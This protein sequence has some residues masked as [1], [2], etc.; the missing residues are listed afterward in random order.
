MGFFEKKEE[1]VKS[2]TCDD[3]IEWARPH[4]SA[5]ALAGNAAALKAAELDGATLLDMRQDQTLIEL[6]RDEG[7]DPRFLH[8]LGCPRARAG[9]GRCVNGLCVASPPMLALRPPS[10]PRC[11]LLGIADSCIHPA[12][13]VPCTTSPLTTRSACPPRHLPRCAE[14]KAVLIHMSENE[15]EDPMIWTFPDQ[16]TLTGMLERAGASGLQITGGTG[17][18]VLRHSTCGVIGRRHLLNGFPRSQRFCQG[19]EGPEHRG[20]EAQDRGRIIIIIRV[21]L[22]NKKSN[23]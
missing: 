2:W 23:R 15:D 9:R 4:V 3:V 7:F 18:G 20:R 17:P 1:E 6:L 19:K 12:R 16:S 13:F 21:L 10:F 22:L 14:T 8:C 11:P 5:K